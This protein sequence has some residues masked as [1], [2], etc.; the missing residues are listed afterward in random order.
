MPLAQWIVEKNTLGTFAF[1]QSERTPPKGC[2]V[3]LWFDKF[4]TVAA[5]NGNLGPSSIDWIGPLN[6]KT[7]GV[8]IELAAFHT[9]MQALVNAGGGTGQCLRESDWSHFVT[10][11]GIAHPIKN[12]FAWHRTLGVPYLPGSGVKG[13]TLAWARDWAGVEGD[14][15]MRIFGVL[16]DPKAVPLNAGSVIFMDA[17]PCA[18][19]KLHAEILTPHGR[20][21]G[22]PE[23]AGRPI[24]NGFLAVAGGTFHFAVLPRTRSV[25]DRTDC[26]TALAWLIAAAETIGAG[27]KTKT[28]YGRFII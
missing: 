3:G 6:N 27:A 20:G 18:P 16:P 13:M 14:D 22:A 9:R 1:G 17:V 12:G 24:P 7:V 19:V 2:N 15:L 26:A 8:D 4:G 25:A 21:S 23:E 10:G 28:G 11:V 5:A